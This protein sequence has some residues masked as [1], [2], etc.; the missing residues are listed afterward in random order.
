MAELPALAVLGFNIKNM[1][2]E[3]IKNYLLTFVFLIIGLFVVTWSINYFIHKSTEDLIVSDYEKLER[4]QVA[5]V[6]G[7]LVYNDGSMSDI[8]KDRADTALE[9]YKKGMVNKI[10]VSGDH[11]RKEYDEVNAVKDYYLE[12]GVFEEDI[13]TDHAGFDTYDSLYRA[14]DIFGVESVIVV[15][16]SFHLPRAVYIARSLGIKVQGYSAD[17][18]FYVLS[19]Y[20]NIREKFASLKAF[21]NVMFKSKPKFLGDQILISGDGRDSWD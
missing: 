16:Q 18:R 6:L 4:S 13:F 2:I 12:N 11:G 9:L 15:T 14:R 17:K 20:N 19:R 1:R 5:L 21:M 10:L 8:L 7:A 3:K